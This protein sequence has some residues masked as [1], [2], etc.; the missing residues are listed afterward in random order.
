MA[1]IESAPKGSVSL[2]LS[3]SG[4]LLGVGM[5]REVVLL[6]VFDDEV[7]LLPSSPFLYSRDAVW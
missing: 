1:L 7:T 4:A 6:K 5:R 2:K 3:F